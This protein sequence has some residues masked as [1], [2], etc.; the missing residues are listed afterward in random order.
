MLDS[1][2][3]EEIYLPDLT[4]AL[5]FRLMFERSFIHLTYL[6]TYSNTN[7]LFAAQASRSTT[8]FLQK[9]VNTLT[10]LFTIGEEKKITARLEV[11]LTRNYLTYPTE[12]VAPRYYYLPN[13]R[14]TLC[15]VE[16]RV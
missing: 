6:P 10:V 13:N 4:I 14:C 8:D 3:E 2:E 7:M 9:Y 1:T 16:G 11:V 12:I 15:G 5:Q